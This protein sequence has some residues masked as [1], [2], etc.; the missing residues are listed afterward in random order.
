MISLA[1]RFFHESLLR[2]SVYLMAST[3]VLSLFGFLFWVVNAR[4]FSA[5]EVGFATTL[6][7]VMNL[8][9]MLSLVGFNASLVR[10]LPQ[11]RRPNEM[12]SSALTIVML[13]SLA[14]AAGFVVFIP[15]LSPR[16]AFVQSSALTIGL[17]VLFSILSSLNTLTDSVFLA[18]RRAHFILIINSIFSAS[19]LVFPHPETQEPFAVEAPL[20]PDFEAALRALRQL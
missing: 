4:L 10:F 14:L 11:N 6:I 3:G 5:E 9:S 18:H 13:T 2:N 8:I 19:R 15:L 7:S 1:Q 17:F 12:I 20:P 16:L